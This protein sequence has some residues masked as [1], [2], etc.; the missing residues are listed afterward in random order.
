[1]RYRIPEREALQIIGRETF[2]YCW[3]G[4]AADSLSRCPNKATMRVYCINLCGVHG[5]E[6]A[7]GARE[8]LTQ[9]AADTL[10]GMIRPNINP[11]LFRAYEKARLY[12]MEETNLAR[13][14]A[15]ALL[16]E[17]F[18][19]PPLTNDFEIPHEY[20]LRTD[21]PELD[22]GVP[23]VDSL[24]STRHHTH[25]LMRESYR[26]GE[27][28]I[29]EHLEEERQ[30]HNVLLSYALAIED[31]LYPEHVEQ[32]RKNERENPLFGESG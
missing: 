7:M 30:R 24:Y 5:E 18:P 14:S 4:K 27:D 11:A 28:D 3:A 20:A 13:E 19:D 32:A 2:P 10:E 31:G 1:M 8:E 12:L 23:W 29:V 15:P 26:R 9:D 17:A 6:A 25:A 16:R 22:A 21:E